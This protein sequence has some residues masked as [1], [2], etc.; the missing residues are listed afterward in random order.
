[1]YGSEILLGGEQE[2]KRGLNSCKIEILCMI[3]ESKRKGKEIART[4]VA[5][6]VL[7]SFLITGRL[8]ISL[9]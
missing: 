6:Q 4:S 2:L 8:L 7:N 9:Y 5:N 3:S 1:M